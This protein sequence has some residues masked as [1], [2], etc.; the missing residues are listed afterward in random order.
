V[1][2]RDRRCCGGVKWAAENAE[3]TEKT[4]ICRQNLFKKTRK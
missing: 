2:L 4:A 3:V 1:S